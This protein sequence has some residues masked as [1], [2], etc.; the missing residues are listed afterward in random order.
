MQKL[1]GLT[2]GSD[3]GAYLKVR[4]GLVLFTEHPSV[5]I[6]SESPLTHEGITLV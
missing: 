2:N 5:K 6:V 4:D 1:G 3:A